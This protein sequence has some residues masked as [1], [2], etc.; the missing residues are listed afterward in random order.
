MLED[1]LEE[2]RKEMLNKETNELNSQDK[3]IFENFLTSCRRKHFSSFRLLTL[4]LYDSF[5]KGNLLN[6]QNRK[7]DH[8]EFGRLLIRSIR[9]VKNYDQFRNKTLSKKMPKN[10][11]VTKEEFNYCLILLR[12]GLS[13]GNWI[14]ET[15]KLSQPATIEMDSLVI[16]PIK[17]AYLFNA[18]E[19]DDGSNIV[20]GHEEV[21]SATSL[22]NDENSNNDC[23]LDSK[24]QEEEEEE[25]DF[26]KAEE[27]AVIDEKK[28]YYL[29]KKHQ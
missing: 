18:D 21:E 1:S 16:S 9:G 25:E 19:V 22:N 20:C 29:R 28:Q 15:K 8:H 13:R 7:P 3:R 2:N 5:E 17:K 23:H 11:V 14:A 27:V 26:D 4:E 24:E 12:C 6:P 10:R